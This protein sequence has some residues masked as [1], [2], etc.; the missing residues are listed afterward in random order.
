MDLAESENSLISPLVARSSQI[1]QNV[2][3]I[4]SASRKTKVQEGRVSCQ[5]S[6]LSHC[7]QA[8][9]DCDLLAAAIATASIATLKL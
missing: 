6:M 3:V 5:L 4:K 9:L 7:P 2:D 1:I 8:S